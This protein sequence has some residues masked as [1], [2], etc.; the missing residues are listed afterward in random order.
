MAFYNDISRYYD[1]IFPVSK[2]TV[3]FIEKSVGNPPKIIL[4]VACGTGGYSM[5][6]AAKGYHLTAVDLDD[7][8]IE[9][10]STKV[11]AS[12]QGVQ[13]MQADMLHLE[14]KFQDASFDGVFCIGNSVV[15]LENLEQIQSF[16]SEVRKLLV[17]DGTFIIQIINYDRIITQD[18]KSLPTIVNDA[19]PLKFERL[20]DYDKNNDKVKFK[21]ILSV[22]NQIIENEIN[23]TPLLYDDAVTLLKSA[24]FHKISAYGDFKRSA[25]DKTKSYS[26]VIE[27]K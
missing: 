18:I 21:T 17:A 6:L 8:M 9:H 16:F 15:H 26:L 4:D 13:F 1:M 3:E 7:Q 2:D 5:E 12:D 22:D 27:A 23:L 14:E 11:K 19:V 20:Y 25:F 10:L 24:G